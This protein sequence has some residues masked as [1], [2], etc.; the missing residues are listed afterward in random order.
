MPS[1]LDRA[2]GYRRLYVDAVAERA[3]HR[4][5]L[6]VA[7]EVARLSFVV[8]GCGLIALIGWALTAGAATRPGAAGWAVVFGAGSLVVTVLGVRAVLAAVRAAGDMRRI[9]RPEGRPDR[10]PQSGR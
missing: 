6:A 9:R 8:A 3:P 5:A 10:P 2:F 1:Y 7:S 4:A